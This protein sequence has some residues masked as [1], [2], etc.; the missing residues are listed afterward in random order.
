MRIAIVGNGIV[1]GALRRWFEG[2]NQPCLVWDPPQ[3]QH[4]R[5]DNSVDVAF[6]SVPV[7]TKGFK[8]D[9]SMLH[10]AIRAAS[11]AKKIVVR[12]TVVPGTCDSLSAQYRR[13]I[14]H[15]P[16]FLTE[17]TADADMEAQDV[18][19]G[20]P[21]KFREDENWWIYFAEVF[22]RQKRIRWASALE[23][24]MAKYAH[25]V[26]GA[27]KVTYFNAVYSLCEKNK[28]R[29]DVVKNLMLASGYINDVHTQVPG[30]D[31][32]FG[33]GG[34]CFPKDLSAFIG[35]AGADPIHIMLNNMLCLN[36]YYRGVDTE[37]ESEKK[38]LE[39]SNG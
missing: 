2:N 4:D 33:Y 17:R 29:F 31:G 22:L 35:F 21:D 3:N 5:I 26:F 9:L 15:M 20:I 11:A 25:N 36:R 28:I 32:R 37:I 16:E 10:D 30:P 6:I 38:P 18:L 27:L 1:G 19:I 8:Q 24:E 14:F 34:K 39:V 13:A 12:S 7:P 23:C